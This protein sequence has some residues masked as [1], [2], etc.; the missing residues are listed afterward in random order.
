VQNLKL[1]RPEAMMDKLIARKSSCAADP[2]NDELHHQLYKVYGCLYLPRAL[3]EG[4][5][6]IES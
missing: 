4:L 5:E 3:V 1:A 6:R 2:R